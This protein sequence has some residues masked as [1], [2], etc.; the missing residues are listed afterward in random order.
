[1]TTEISRSTITP[2]IMAGSHMVTFIP[3]ATADTL[4]NTVI[5]S[6]RGKKFECA[7]TVSVTDVNG[8]LAGM[9]RRK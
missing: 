4:G 1:M 3:R 6:L 2:R 5:P 8:R 9:Q 7:D